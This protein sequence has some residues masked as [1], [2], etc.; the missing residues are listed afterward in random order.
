[1]GLFLWAVLPLALVAAL[2]FLL[3]QRVRTPR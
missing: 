2:L 3:Y 1:M